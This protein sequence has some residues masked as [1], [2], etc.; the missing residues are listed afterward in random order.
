VLKENDM[1]ELSSKGA[2]IIQTRLLNKFQ[3][4]QFVLGTQYSLRNPTYHLIIQNTPVTVNLDK[5]PQDNFSTWAYDGV[6]DQVFARNLKEVDKY[7]KVYKTNDG[8]K[9]MH[10]QKVYE[11]TENAN[12]QI[13][14]DAFGPVVSAIK[15]KE[16]HEL[17]KK[18]A[19]KYLKKAQK[20]K[21]GKKGKIDKVNKQLILNNKDGEF[22]LKLATAQLYKVINGNERYICCGLFP[23][24]KNKETD[25]LWGEIL[26]KTR[27]VI[28][29]RYPDSTTSRQMRA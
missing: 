28:K 4:E 19:E 14:Q 24:E 16:K 15:N 11:S 25:L 12:E 8:Y 17:M 18:I 21:I 20:L 1:W 13:W 23:T 3:K 7:L 22:H 29:S 5:V 27:M 6:S 26:A 2:L 10:N 9:V